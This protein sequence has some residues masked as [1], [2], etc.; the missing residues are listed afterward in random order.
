MLKLFRD[1]KG[2]AEVIGSLMFIV[3]LLFFFTNVYLWHDLA[4]KD[5]N[6]LNIK[7]IS[8]AFDITID[9]QTSITVTAHNS[10]ITLSRVW[11]I[12]TDDWHLYADLNLP[13]AA[14]KTA[15]I[16]LEQSA[17]QYCYVDASGSIQHSAYPTG[18]AVSCAV[19]NTLG[20]EESSNF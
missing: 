14:G 16:N 6:Q 3:I 10:A 7:Q 4:N 5:E 15:T 2:T 19:I 9:S 11:I 17:L 12:T 18:K 13:L 1:R 8:A 20:I